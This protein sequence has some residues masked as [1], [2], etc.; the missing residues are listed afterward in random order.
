MGTTLTSRQRLLTAIANEKPDVLPVTTHHVMPYYLERFQNNI[1]IQEFFDKFGFDSIKWYVSQLPDTKKGEYTK[2][3]NKKRGFLEMPVIVSDNWQVKEEQLPNDKYKTVKYTVVT[4]KKALTM[5]LQSNEY[6]T[7]IT[8]H[9]IKEDEDIEVIANYLPMP[10]GDVEGSK[11]ALEEI[12]EKG[13]L[14]T[15]IPSTIDMFGQPGC[16]QDACCMYGTEQLIMKTYD[17]P[18]W[19][20]QLLKIIKGR[21]ENYINTLS[22]TA[23]DIIELGG[24]DGCTSVISPSIFDDYVAPYD[25]SLI[26][27]AH[28]NG[29]KISYHLC[30]SK[31]A[32]IDSIAHM[33]M[34]AL[35]TLTP[36][37]M[38]GDADLRVIKEKLGDKMC[39]I[40][41]FDQNNNFVSGT[42]EQTRQ[43]VTKCF[44]EAGENGGYIIAPSDH[45]FD[46]KDELLYAFTQQAHSIKY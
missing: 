24:G 32:L 41:G 35:E 14:R 25:K 43:A 4:P 7:W 37:A 45:F 9:I 38:G 12:G 33:G 15:H 11:S 13:I 40:G 18:S 17:D 20:H 34:D 26:E 29:M 23:Y 31:M 36:V 28:K 8:E 46:A 19:V 44:E 6:T 3:S 2:D 27:T 21:K 39:L 5:I 42:E 16:W 10:I 1:S 30:G 22:N